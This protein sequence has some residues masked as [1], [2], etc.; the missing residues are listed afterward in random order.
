MRTLVVSQSSTLDGSIEMLGDGFDPQGQAAQTELVEEVQR[1]AHQSD[2]LLAGRY[3]FEALRGYWPNQPED[4]TGVTKH[5]N[6]VRKYV[7]S[8]TITDPQGQN[9]TVLRGDP[10]PKVRILKEEQGRDIVITGSISLCHTLI[11]AGLV[12]EYRLFIY[13][14]VQGRGRRLFPDGF[15]LAR[16]RLLETR[17]FGDIIYARYARQNLSDTVS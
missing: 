17:A 4:P 14:V 6:E 16:L 9:T 1:Q 3:T 12:D 8:S 7:V 15:E 2:A 13:P 11:N 10:V 5:L